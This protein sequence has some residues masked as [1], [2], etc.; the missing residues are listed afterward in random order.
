MF[1]LSPITLG[2][3]LFMFA[4]KAE[5]HDKQ[6]DA[7]S[8]SHTETIQP[9]KDAGTQTSISVELGME[10]AIPFQRESKFQLTPEQETCVATYPN[11]KAENIRTGV[12]IAGVEGTAVFY[13]PCSDSIK[14]NCIT[15]AEH[16]AAK[17]DGL[18]AKVIEGQS[19]LGVAG[20][21]VALHE[22]CTAANQSNCI[23]TSTYKTID[24]SSKNADGAVGL[25]SGNVNT[26]MLIA[27]AF[28]YWDE[29]GTRYT[30]TG[31][32]NILAAN[33][34]TGISIFGVTGTADPP[35]DCN[36]IG[37][38]GTWVLVPGD[39]DFGT[40]DFCVMKYEAK[41]SSNTPVSEAAG[42]P[43][44]SIDQQDAITEC[45]SLGNG[46]HLL[47]NDEYMTIASNLANVA[48]NWSGNAVGSGNLY[49]G[50]S[51][52][53]PASACPA[54]A[55]DLK[56]FV[57]TDCTAQAAGGTESSEST[58]RRTMTL[59]NGNVI[60]DLSGNVREWTSYFNNEDKPTPNDT[61]YN[62]FTLPIAGTDSLPLSDLI[63]TNALKSF[64]DNNWD[65][66]Q[67][68]G[69]GRFG[70]DGG[71]GGLTRGGGYSG[72]DRNGIFRVRLD[73]EPTQTSATLGFRCA[74]SRL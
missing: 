17:M 69:K 48:S 32:A 45:A 11:L 9:S 19:V 4:C 36:S 10:Q 68:V 18:A 12:S 63:P 43:W 64:W 16:P 30:N 44:G 27:S 56:A 6:E 37:T 55:D 31:D 28:E 3:F 50:H 40:D 58:Q 20:T 52:S 61:V 25:N 49:R 26:R 41:N 66:D 7:A 34:D 73:Q 65:S 2:M 35:P 14:T 5:H 72:G 22:E 29:N 47:T 59:S 33:I 13:P 1:R 15:T 23:A 8:S 38:A 51:D 24:L 39:P 42:N 67:G 74:V 53:D 46:F 70:S 21:G 57:E 54:D 62:E 60:W 71:G